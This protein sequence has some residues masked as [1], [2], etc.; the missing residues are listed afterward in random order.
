MRWEFIPTPLPFLPMISD[1]S[2]ETC[3]R[4]SL[5][6]CKSSSLAVLSGPISFLLDVWATADGGG[7]DGA[8]R[9][10]LRLGCR[11]LAPPPRLCGLHR[12]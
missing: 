5:F 10:Q 8:A 3:E 11:P 4:E 7:V 9:F 12:I 2:V 6:C 1:T